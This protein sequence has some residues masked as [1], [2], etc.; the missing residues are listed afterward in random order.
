MSLQRYCT[1]ASALA[2]SDEALSSTKCLSKPFVILLCEFW[3]CLHFLNPASLFEVEFIL[4]CFPAVLLQIN[5]KLAV[6]N[7]ESKFSW[8]LLT[9]RFM[10]FIFVFYLFQLCVLLFVKANWMWLHICKWS[11]CVRVSKRM[12]MSFFFSGCYG[13]DEPS[14]IHVSWLLARVSSVD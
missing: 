13:N 5:I 3:C 12:Q 7:S 10:L 14:D 1:C 6:H 8:F 11:T 4:V 9:A 2:G